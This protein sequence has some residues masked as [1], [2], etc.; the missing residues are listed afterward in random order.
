[1][2]DP[3]VRSF[4]EEETPVL[5]YA[6]AGWRKQ[7]AGC[8]QVRRWNGLVGNVLYFEYEMS[9]TGQYI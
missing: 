5:A 8:A 3:Y 6:W 1:M 2:Q 4:T 7:E 9:L